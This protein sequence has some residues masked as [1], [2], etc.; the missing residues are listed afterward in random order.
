M[1]HVRRVSPDATKKDLKQL[2]E[3][4]GALKSVDL[5]LYDNGQRGSI[6]YVDFCEH[7]DAKNAKK[8]LT[9]TLL[10]GR[11][12]VVKWALDIDS[13]DDPEPPRAPRPITIAAYPPRHT[14]KR[15]ASPVDDYEQQVEVCERIA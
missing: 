13:M 15:R 10:R 11:S 12:L 8:A 6:A 7:Q 5:P 14:K 3:P 2:F 1:L 4:F 9:N